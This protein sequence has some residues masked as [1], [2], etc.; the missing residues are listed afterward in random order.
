MAKLL[1]DEDPDLRREALQH[2]DR[3]LSSQKA[4]EH[5]AKLLLQNPIFPLVQ[6]TL[7]DPERG[8]RAA[9][10]PVAASL[11]LAVQGAPMTPLF[12]QCLKDEDPQIRVGAIRALGKSGTA[13]NA[14]RHFVPMLADGD[15]DV[16]Q[17]AA[18]AL[19]EVGR[20]A[21]SPIT[22]ALQDPNIEVRIKACE[23]LGKIGPEA[24]TAAGALGVCLADADPR[25]RAEAAEALIQIGEKAL[26]ACREALAHEDPGVRLYAAT[27]LAHLDPKNSAEQVL[28]LLRDKL[29]EDTKEGKGEDEETDPVLVKII[30]A[31]GRIGPSIPKEVFPVLHDCVKRDDPALQGEAIGA[32]AHLGKE[33]APAVPTL[34]PLLKDT[35][36]EKL[37]LT[38]ISTLGAIGPEAKEAVPALQF[39]LQQESRGPLFSASVRALARIDPEATRPLLASLKERLEGGN[40]Q[41]IFLLVTLSRDLP[42]AKEILA[43][44]QRKQNQ[45]S[46]RR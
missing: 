40:F 13:R 5:K 22:T 4:L 42:E 8:V 46:R 12:T 33:A 24:H 28:P 20:A 25:V 19:V 23:I 27:A 45:Q 9:A 35:E 30:R 3:L 31:L 44:Y 37:R 11:T 38:I 26:P 18:D 7:K 16:R 32:L 14:V 41:S 34:V 6:K 15:A 39:F 1:A 17:A 43:E 21:A 10:L 29:G 2:L 36:E